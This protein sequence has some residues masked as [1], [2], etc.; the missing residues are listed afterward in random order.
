[1][2]P[3]VFSCLKSLVSGGNTNVA[4]VCGR[5]EG[6]QYG[7]FGKPRHRVSPSAWPAS[8]NK[9]LKVE[10]DEDNE[11]VIISP[12]QM[13]QMSNSISEGSQCYPATRKV[14]LHEL[15]KKAATRLAIEWP[16]LHDD[17]QG[18]EFD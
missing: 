1:M 4:G 9:F 12:A 18:V 16:A 7:G 17:G 3:A 5:V 14:N 11:N 8:Q 15:H 13:S 10:N 2:T 6:G